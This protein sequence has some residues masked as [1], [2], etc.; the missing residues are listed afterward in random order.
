MIWASHLVVWQDMDEA[1]GALRHGVVF[2]VER[3]QDARQVTQRGNLVSQMALGTEKA[4]SRR[5]DCLQ[6]LTLE[7]T[8]CQID[9]RKYQTTFFSLFF[10]SWYILMLTLG[11]FFSS[12]SLRVSSSATRKSRGFRRTHPGWAMKMRKKT[13]PTSTSPCP[14]P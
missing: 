9:Y 12:I 11:L 4:N 13:P 14:A 2:V 7:E 8:T 3:C 1:D 10:L 5:G 6:S